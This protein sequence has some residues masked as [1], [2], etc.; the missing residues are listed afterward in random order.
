MSKQIYDYVLKLI[1]IGDSC[2]GKSNLLLQF[3]DKRFNP[4]HELTIGIEFGIKIIS[5]GKTKY[6]LQIWDTAGQEAFKSITNSYYRNAIGCLLVYDVTDRKTFDNINHWFSD[7]KSLCDKNTEFVLVGNK[8]D[9]IDIK[10]TENKRAVSYEE[11]KKFA[12][13]HGMSFFETSAVKGI[14]IEECFT[15]IVSMVQKKIDSNIIDLNKT[16]HK[17]IQLANVSANNS[18]SDGLSQSPYSSI[19]KC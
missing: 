19:C 1:I 15:H 17:G 7:A 16:K 5:Y 4:L 11:G 18:T 9:V 12:D 13:D 10:N 14:N 2:V 3:T 8:I 6:K